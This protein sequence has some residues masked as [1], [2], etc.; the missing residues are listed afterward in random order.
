VT[1]K[2]AAVPGLSITRSARICVYPSYSSGTVAGDGIDLLKR[3]VHTEVCS[4]QRSSL[5]PLSVQK[6]YDRFVR[7]LLFRVQGR[8]S[9]HKHRDARRHVE[10]LIVRPAEAAILAKLEIDSFARKSSGG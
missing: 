4:S 9:R 2:L 8:R 5:K 3:E 10:T 1:K 7:I 6:R